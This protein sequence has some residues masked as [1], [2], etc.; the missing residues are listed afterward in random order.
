MNLPDGYRW[1]T[2]EEVEWWR[3]DPSWFPDALIVP[4]LALPINT[5]KRSA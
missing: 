5:I 1:M 2:A 3:K 4:G